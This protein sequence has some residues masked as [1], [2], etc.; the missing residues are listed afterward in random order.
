MT[1]RLV[2]PSLWGRAAGASDPR[3]LISA[4]PAKNS[5]LFISSPQ[6]AYGTRL[7]LKTD[8]KN[9][10]IHIYISIK[11]LLGKPAQGM[12]V[13]QSGEFSLVTQ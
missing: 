12:Q 13:H 8:I 6:Q 10:P 5:F 4:W 7:Y 2:G 3:F 11:A 1:P 9:L